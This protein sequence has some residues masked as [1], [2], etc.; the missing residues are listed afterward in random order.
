MSS[1]TFITRLTKASG[2]HKLGTIMKED[3]FEILK[4]RKVIKEGHFLLTSGLHSDLYFEKF[5]ILEDPQFLEELITPKI[6]D[7][8]QLNPEAVVG[9]TTGGALLAFSIARLLG[10]KAFFAEKNKEGERVFKR[11]FSLRE[12]GRVLVVDDVLTTG[13]SIRAT[14]KAV[15]AKNWT[16]VGIFVLIDRNGELD[17]GLPLFSLLLFKANQWRPEDCPLCKE[18]ISIEKPGGG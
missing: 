5:R 6:A 9:P 12:K 8:K 10:I 14:L 15:K 18:N 1:S 17:F 7:L 11:G 13:G 2:R 16:P 3:L 4:D